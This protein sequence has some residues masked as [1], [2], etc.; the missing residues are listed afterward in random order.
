MHRHL[1][2]YDYW[3]EPGDAEAAPLV[4]LHG[5]GDDARSFLALGQ[6]VAPKATRLAVQGNVDEGGMARFFRRTAMGVYDMA[7]LAARTEAFARFLDAAI[8]GHGLDR[9]R[10]V[11]LGYSNGA[12]LLANLAFNAPEALRR[13]VLLHPLMP[14]DPPAAD[15]SGMDVLLTAGRHDPICPWPR[16]ERLAGAFRD[17]GATV[18]VVAHQGGHELAAEEL[19]AAREFAAS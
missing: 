9:A 16:T 4:L 8:E 6:S 7:D 3:L 15:L 12:N 10:T 1:A 17:R 14:F 2:G 11:G 13:L 19:A 18:R 5:T